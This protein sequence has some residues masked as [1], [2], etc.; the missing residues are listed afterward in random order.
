MNFLYSIIIIVSIIILSP[1]IGILLPLYFNTEGTIVLQIFLTSFLLLSAFFFYLKIIN[2]NLSHLYNRIDKTVKKN[3]YS[4]MPKKHKN[5][6]ANIWYFFYNFET[7]LRNYE[8]LINSQNILLKKY[9]LINN[10]LKNTNQIK[11]MMLEV[12][13]SIIEIDNTE[14]FFNLILEKLIDI[15]DDGHKGSFLVL[16]KD[17]YLEYKAS[18]GF[19]INDL[20]KIKIKLEETFLWK[21]SPQNISKPCI[22]DD[23]RSFN[24]NSLNKKSFNALDD[25]EAL[26]IKT[27]L[28]TPVIIDDKLYGMINIDSLRKNAFNEDDLLIAEYFS[29]QISIA[30]K[31]HQLIEKILYLSR[32][33]SLTNTY[34]RCYFEEIVKNVYRKAIR[35][36]EM[37][38]IVM[39]D[40]NNL[41]NT[42]DTFG[43][44]VGDMVISRFS[45]VIKD[46]IR[47]SDLFARYGGDEFIAIFFNSNPT[48]IEN[49]LSNIV[50]YCNYHPL[51]VEGK[52]VYVSFS[53]GIS[54]FPEESEDIDFLIKLADKRM[55]KYKKE[56]KAKYNNLD[57]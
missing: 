39:F 17:N 8:R 9:A 3:Q 30:I 22:I 13:N 43:H 53:Y 27:T 20:K 36:N 15:V 5:H 55:Y 57:F 33:D 25:I 49:R 54:H 37:F 45:E 10:K 21:K 23:I 44:V 7:I 2:R 14:K 42:N 50:N 56:F 31:N 38:S 12:S 51:K 40:L 19:N 18:I 24:S 11:E 35:Y 28:S 29:N 46:N 4:P 52:D 1:T 26:N 6:F 16:N 47:E 41:K 32:Y 34:N 48:D